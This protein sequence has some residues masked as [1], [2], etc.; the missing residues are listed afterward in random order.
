VIYGGAHTTLIRSR[1]D[2]H[3]WEAIGT[4]TQDEYYC[5]IS[6]GTNLYAQSANTG[7]NTTGPNHY[8]TS[9]ES[10]GTHWTPYNDQAFSDGPLP[11]EFDSGNRI[12]YSANWN[13]GF[14]ALELP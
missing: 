12:I 5:V 3:N 14:W 9:P 11:M 4:G 2:G 6:D 13:G 7:S 10:D 1:D 8:I